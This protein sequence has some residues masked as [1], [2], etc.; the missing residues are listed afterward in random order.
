MITGCFIDISGAK[1]ELYGKL[2]TKINSFQREPALSQPSSKERDLKLWGKLLLHHLLSA[3]S[4]EHLLLIDDLRINNWG[5][6]YFENSD[7]DF[8]IAHSGAIIF[9][10][11]VQKARLGVDIEK[12]E[13]RDFNAMREY[14]CQREWNLITASINSKAEFYKIWARKEACI[15]AT[16]RGLSQPLDEI[17]VSDNEVILDGIRW[18]LQDVFIKP[19]YGCCIAANQKPD[20]VIEEVDFNKLQLI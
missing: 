14:F 3:N 20:I 4:L 6:P 7:F 9:C 10:A 19:G 16:G 1:G 12:E 2:L 11:G 15:K 5:K 13:D 18:F 8:N 17:D